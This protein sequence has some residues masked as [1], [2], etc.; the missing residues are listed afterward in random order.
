MPFKSSYLPHLNLLM[1]SSLFVK[2]SNELTF[3]LLGARNCPHKAIEN[4]FILVT[5]PWAV[6]LKH[7]D[8]TGTR[9]Y[10]AELFQTKHTIWFPSWFLSGGDLW[11]TNCVAWRIDWILVLIWAGEMVQWIEHL[12][13]NCKDLSLKPEHVRLDKVAHIYNSNPSRWEVETEEYLEAH[14]SEA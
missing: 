12:P 10:Y 6:G 3:F 9:G 11:S 8:F 14:R 1:D 5:L 4:P 2:I 13:C 7:S